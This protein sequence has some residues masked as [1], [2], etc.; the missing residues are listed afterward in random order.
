M[1]EAIDSLAGYWERRAVRFARQDDGLAAVCSYGMPRFYNRA[2][3]MCQRR[4]LHP[5]LQ[6]IRNQD[7][8]EIG[9]GV[10]R[11]T[12]LLAGGGNRVT[13]IDLSPTMIDETRARLEKSGFGA[14]LH[15]ADVATFD[16]QRRFDW[17]ISVTVIQHVTNETDFRQVF[18]NLSR[19]VR[20]GGRV[21][22]LEAAP[23][24]EVRRCDSPI[25]RAR[26]Q[27]A[28]TEALEASGFS[29]DHISGVD[30]MPFKTWVLPSLRAM[31]R[32]AAVAAMALVTA[33]SL[34]LDLVLARWLPGQSWH[35]LIVATRTGD[36]CTGI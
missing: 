6:R 24:G 31:P 11:W 22:L 23:A 33:T 15:V 17:A 3:E 2:I 8:L 20:P 25:F 29:V 27:R 9:C 18:A 30:P 10:G 5:W 35:K 1:F 4:A 28:Y 7:V 32:P 19:Q 14:E 36:P 26:P 13:A 16:A 21:V 34:P 12:K